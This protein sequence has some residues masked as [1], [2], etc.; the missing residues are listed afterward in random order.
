MSQL[1][2]INPLCLFFYL[3]VFLRLFIKVYTIYTEMCTNHI[4]QLNEFSQS[5]HAGVTKTWSKWN[6]ARTSGHYFLWKTLF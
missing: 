4:V 1:R 2:L 5:K 3:L 6:I